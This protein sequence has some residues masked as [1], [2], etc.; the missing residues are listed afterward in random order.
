MGL[1]DG[2]ERQI[3][4]IGRAHLNRAVQ[5][6]V[7]A[8]QVL[9]KNEW[10]ESPSVAVVEEEEEEEENVL[11]EDAKKDEAS[12]HN[13]RDASGETAMEIVGANG[14]D[15]LQPTGQVVGIVRRNW[16]PYVLTWKF[17][18]YLA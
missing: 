17:V 14:L 5:N 13:A 11:E 2:T 8:V 15:S 6:D 3:Y 4:I 9:P 16:R 18:V 7:V 12:V 1:V 10:R